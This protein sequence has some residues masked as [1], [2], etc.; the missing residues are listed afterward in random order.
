[1]SEMGQNL[2]EA[3]QEVLDHAQG[4]IEL[5]TTRIPVTPIVIGKPHVPILS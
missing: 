2:I 1:M 5:R 3:M 4:K